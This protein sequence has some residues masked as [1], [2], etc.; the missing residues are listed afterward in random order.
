[1]LGEIGRNSLRRRIH[2]QPR[3]TEVQQLHR[4]LL[5]DENVRRFQV[6]VHDEMLVRMVDRRQHFEEQSQP[7][8][9]GAT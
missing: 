9:D 3:D 5:V 7:R 6:T 4:A 1:M 8:V 2:Q